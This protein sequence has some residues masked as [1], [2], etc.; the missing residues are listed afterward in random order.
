MANGCRDTQRLYVIAKLGVADLLATGPLD[1][2]D[3]ASKLQVH[4]NSL[5]RVMRS[6]AAQGVFTQDL[7]DKFGLTPMSQLLR[8]DS[9][10]SMRHAVIF[11]GE[12]YYRALG[13][14][15]HTVKTG[16]TAFNHL[17]GQGHFDFL[18]KNPEVSKTFN[19]FMAQSAGRY[20]DTFESFDFAGH[21]LI[22]DVGGG[23]GNLL[24]S[25][26]KS[27][28]HLKGIVY[29]LPQGVTET[30]DNLEEAGVADRCTIVTGSFF[31]AVPSGG[32]VYLLSRILHDWPD[33]K[34]KL[35]LSNCRKSMAKNGKLLIRDAIIP[36]GDTPSP[37]KQIDITMLFMLGG[38]ERTKAE[39]NALLHQSG[40]SISQV[41][42]TDE[43]WDL[44]EAR[45]V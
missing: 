3:L 41:I 15:L 11:F 21:H 17:Y 12:E 6:L 38:A 10:D 39:W 35:I 22:V 36:D 30:Q 4:K 9:P 7:T 16:E 42:K 44:V 24:A 13:E 28:T 20:R 25:I 14:L 43:P 19:S 33:E 2:D 34:A 29:D 23:H 1:C 27:H 31:D 18:G 32:D 26:L 8:S 5:F 37:G 45:P 40:F